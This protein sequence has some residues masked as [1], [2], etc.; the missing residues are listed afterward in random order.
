MACCYTSQTTKHAGL[1]RI[2]AQL[3]VSAQSIYYNQKTYIT[4]KFNYSREF[5]ATLRVKL[6]N[7][8]WIAVVETDVDGAL[9]VVVKLSGNIDTPKHQ[10]R[11]RLLPCHS[12]SKMKQHVIGT[13]SGHIRPRHSSYDDRNRQNWHFD[14]APP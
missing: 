7:H 11:R 9:T 10:R 13:R 2:Y 4:W 3:F 6:W 5:V 8:W 14:R 12:G 1:V